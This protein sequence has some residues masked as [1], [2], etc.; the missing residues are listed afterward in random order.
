M[1]HLIL[2]MLLNGC[3]TIEKLILEIPAPQIQQIKHFG[4]NIVGRA[5]GGDWCQYD[6]FGEL[7]IHCFPTQASCEHDPSTFDGCGIN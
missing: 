4:S 7:S 6:V 5:E 3:I 2:F 1:K